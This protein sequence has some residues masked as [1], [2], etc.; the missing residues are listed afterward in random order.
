M[1]IKQRR[2][3]RRGVIIQFNADFVWGAATSGPQAE[4]TFHK[5]HENIFDYHYHT[6]PQDFHHNVGPDVASNFYND[7][8]ADLKLLKRAGVQALRISIQ[9][10][11]LIDDLE[12][13]T[14]DQA[15]ADYYR[16]V[17]AAMHDL[18]ITPYVNL[19]HFDL[20]VVLQHQYGGWQSKHVV[21]L[22][23]KFAAR[24]FELFSDQVTHW[25]TFNEPKVIVDGQYLYQFHYPNIV[26]GKAA[27][28][29]AYNLNLASAKAIAVFRKL[30]RNPKGTIGTIINLTPVYPASQADN[31]RVAAHFAELWANDLYMEPAIHG[32]FPEELVDRFER[33]GVLW[34]ATSDELDII[35]ANRI[36]VLGVNYYHPFRVQAPAIDPESL[37]P[38]LPDIYFDHYELPGRKMNLDKGW[39][40]YPAALYDIAMN[41]KERYDNIPWFVAE[42]GIGVADET[43]FLK[44]G[45]IQDDYRIRFMTEHLQFLN[46]AIAKGANCHGYFSWTG[47]DCWSWLNAYKNRYGLIRNDLRT[48]TKSLKKSGYWFQKVS[49]T[50]HVPELAMQSGNKGR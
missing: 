12:E 25:F 50:G 16:R 37:Q 1:V 39:E 42:N 29:V 19:H 35:S 2:G 11:R 47:I 7:Y 10:T 41:I 22:Y 34:D 13:A 21:E 40:I 4:G 3:E 43:R 20:P 6:R 27:V 30:N 31:D 46:R 9:W 8:I 33:D 32:Y 5:K 45:V 44:D 15:G 24:C 14:V 28:Q 36:D 49:S 18:G 26:D 17:F 38:W 48:Q 23:E